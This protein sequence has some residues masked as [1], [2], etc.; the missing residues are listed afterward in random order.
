MNEFHLTA[1]HH[2]KAV[3]I[4]TGQVW[5][6]QTYELLLKDHLVNRY[7]PQLQTNRTEENKYLNTRLFC[8]LSHLEFME[9]LKLSS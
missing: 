2:N 4:L 5:R 6:E 7:R 9:G 8:K 3:I 1:F